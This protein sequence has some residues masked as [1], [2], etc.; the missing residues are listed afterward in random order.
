M[1]IQKERWTLLIQ[2]NLLQEKKEPVEPQKEEEKDQRINPS[3]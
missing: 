1:P 2:D 3:F